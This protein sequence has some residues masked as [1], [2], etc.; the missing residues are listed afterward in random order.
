MDL[1][2]QSSRR[3]SEGKGCRDATQVF[4]VMQGSSPGASDDSLCCLRYTGR[5]Y[6]TKLHKTGHFNVII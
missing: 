5:E 4:F 6:D 1:T 2:Y 3:I